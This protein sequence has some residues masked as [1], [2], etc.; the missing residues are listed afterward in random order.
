M[1][2]KEATMATIDWVRAELL[3]RQSEISIREIARREGV[4]EGAVRKR[5]KAQGWERE[6]VTSVR[7]LVRTGPQATGAAQSSGTLASAEHGLSFSED[8]YGAA[9][10][11]EPE[12]LPETSPADPDAHADASIRLI[13]QID[14]AFRDAFRIFTDQ[15]GWL[16]AIGRQPKLAAASRLLE[17][18]LATARSRVELVFVDGNPTEFFTVGD[19]VG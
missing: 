9:S 18:G 10:Y 13:A 6:T 16:L 11:E 3:Y 8:D 12:P 4:S 14:P 7:S 2:R 15:E 17:E 1:R 5:A 19:V